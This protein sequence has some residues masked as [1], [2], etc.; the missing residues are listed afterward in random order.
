MKIDYWMQHYDVI[1][2]PRWRTVAN[3][4]VVMSLSAYLSN[5]VH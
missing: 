2:N 3:M 1:A 5:L 4:K